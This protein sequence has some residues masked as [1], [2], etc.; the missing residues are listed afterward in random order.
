MQTIRL[1]GLDK[2]PS[3][4]EGI[5]RQFHAIDWTNEL[6]AEL[7]FIADQEKSV[8]DS[9]ASPGGEPWAPNAPRTIK[10]KGHSQ[11]LRGKEGIRESNVKATKRRSAVRHSRSRGIAGFRLA[12][13]LT[14]KANESYGDGVREAIATDSGGVLSFGTTVPYAMYNQLGTSRIPARPFLDFTDRYLDQAT[15]RVADFALAQL[16]K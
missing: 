7:D 6:R 11:I 4:Y 8:F 3:L 15:N 2:L 1:E 16:A 9:S 10:E 14:F 5:D 13:S 12:T